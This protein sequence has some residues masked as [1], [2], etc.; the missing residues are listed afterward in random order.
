VILQTTHLICEVLEV[1]T[2][3]GKAHYS[4]FHGFELHRPSIKGTKLLLKVIKAI[5]IIR[6]KILSTVDKKNVYCRHKRKVIVS[7]MGLVAG[8]ASM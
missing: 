8:K 1:K 6:Q 4:N 2:N 3:E 7:V 5:I